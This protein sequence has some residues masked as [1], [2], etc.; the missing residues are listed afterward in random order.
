MTVLSNLSIILLAAE[1]FVIALVPLILCGGLVYGLW[2]LQRHENLPSWLKLAQAYLELG[3]AYVE[4]AMRAVVKPVLLVHSTVATVQNWLSV[5][6]K[7]VKR[8]Q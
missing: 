3:R 7:F 4:M 8:R 5:I 1:A 2:W 6:T